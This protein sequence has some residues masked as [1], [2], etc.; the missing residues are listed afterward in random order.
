MSDKLSD[1]LAKYNSMMD[2]LGG[3]S[4]GGCVIKRPAG[5]HTNGGCRCPKDAMKM[6][7]AMYV[8]NGLR[9]A[10]SA[11]LAA[12]PAPAIPAVDSVAIIEQCA[13]LADSMAAQGYP[14]NVIG[15]DIRALKAAPA[16]S[17][18]DVLRHRALA[19]EARLDHVIK[20]LTRIHSFLL[21]N[22]VHLPDGRTFEFNNPKIEHEMLRGLR[23]AIRA[24]PDEIAA[25]DAARKG[26]NRDDARNRSFRRQGARTWRQ[27]RW[28]R[29]HARHRPEGSDMPVLRARR[30]LRPLRQ[31]QAHAP[32]LDRRHGNRHR[33]S[34]V[35]VQ[36]VGAHH[37]G[38]L[39]VSLL[40]LIRHHKPADRRATALGAGRPINRALR[41]PF[42]QFGKKLV[43]MFRKC[44]LGAC[45]LMQDQNKTV[46]PVRDYSQIKIVNRIVSHLC[47]NKNGRRAQRLIPPDNLGSKPFFTKKRR[48]SLDSRV[49]KPCKS[50]FKFRAHIYTPF[51][52]GFDPIMA[53]STY[54]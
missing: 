40:A 41:I 49:R 17:E 32:R 28:L 18:S 26:R 10:V 34:F 31:V 44:L 23:D 11:F 4:D 35:G 37:H 19:A 24:V 30:A 50:I 22:D 15:R 47:L 48:N 38:G 20:I 12:S 9:D 8:A 2:H 51:D 53:G 16:I 39:Q 3:C 27:P 7:R 43:E 46:M 52:V 42:R 25:I 29:G 1:A 45:G 14:A 13:A 21:P 33:T 6:Q 54:E 36:P 5:M